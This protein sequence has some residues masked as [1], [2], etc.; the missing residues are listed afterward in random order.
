MQIIILLAFPFFL[1]VRVKVSV[2]LQLL[3]AGI[4]K[5]KGQEASLGERQRQV[6]A[7]QPCATLLEG[8]SLLCFPCFCLSRDF[9]SLWQLRAPAWAPFPGCLTQGLPAAPQPL[10][11]EPLLHL[12]PFPKGQA[13]NEQL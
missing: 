3:F 10:H 1:L 4:Q 13:L 12:D 7:G 2:A 9:T 8:A 5:Q 11:S 6:R